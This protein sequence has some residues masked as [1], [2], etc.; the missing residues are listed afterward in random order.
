M[1]LEKDRGNLHLTLLLHIVLWLHKKECR[2]EWRSK[3]YGA[4]S[5]AACCGSEVKPS[6]WNAGD[7]SLIPGSGRSPGE[8][9]WHPTPVFLPGESHGGRS[10]VGYCPWGLKESDRTEQLYFHF[11]SSDGTQSLQLNNKGNQGKTTTL[12]VLYGSRMSQR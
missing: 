4:A 1:C 12:A 9:K 2:G 7:P 8:G 6:A 3:Q 10:L 5:I 11:L